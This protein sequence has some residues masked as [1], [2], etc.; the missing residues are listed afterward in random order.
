MKR[1]ILAIILLTIGA[2]SVNAQKKTLWGN[3][4]YDINSKTFF[5]MNGSDTIL[6]IR[7]D[8]VVFRVPTNIEGGEG[9]IAEVDSLMFVTWGRLYKVIDSIMAIETEIA[10]GFGLQSTEENELMADS[11][12]LITWGRLYK[13]ID[14]VASVLTASLDNKWN[15]ADS[16]NYLSYG[17]GYKIADSLGAKIDLKLNISDTTAMLDPYAR[18]SDLLSIYS[19]VAYT[20]GAGTTVADSITTDVNTIYTVEVIAHGFDASTGDAVAIKKIGHFR[21]KGGTLVKLG[22][23][24]I[25]KSADTDLSDA[26]LDFD[27]DDEYIT[28]ILTGDSDASTMEWTIRYTV[29]QTFLAM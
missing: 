8:S 3:G 28:F 1:I 16:L 9:G 6:T 11:L 5:W 26:D 15:K 20:A 2:A 4:G 14:S 23:D 19:R 10:L 22:E 25:L 21:N 17:R 27:V 18:K 12:T 29:T 7:P 24:E 13:A